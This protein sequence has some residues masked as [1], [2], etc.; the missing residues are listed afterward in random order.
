MRKSCR[1]AIGGQVFI[2]ARGDVLLDAA[3]MNGVD[4]PHDCRAG[5]CG[6]CRVRVVD[7]LAIGGECG[8]P[9]A[10]RACQCRILSDVRLEIEAVPEVATTTGRVTKIQ[11]RGPDVVEVCIEPAQPFVYLPGQYVR[12]QFRGYPA[13]C[14][15]P[16]VSMDNFNAREFLHLQ[17]QRIRGGRVSAAIGRG[18]RVGHRVR[19]EGPLGTAFLRPASRRR[20]VLVSSGTGFA[21]IWSIAVAAIRE[22]R[23]RRIT[24]VVGARTIES[25]YMI[26]ALCRLARHPNVT[27][28]PVVEARQKLSPVVRT[29]NIIDHMPQLSADDTVHACGSP[30]LVRAVA[31]IAAE[32]GVPCYSDPFIPQDG[33]TLFRALDWINLDWI[34]SVTRTPPIAEKA[35]RPRSPPRLAAVSPFPEHAM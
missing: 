35:G 30:R 15:S 20:L 29:G 33:G 3:L 10:V 8:E 16:T 17:V 14:Y 31:A 2:A 12:A 32:A 24:L 19:I 9:G 25:L 23:H 18:I 13:R 21:P 11:E 34:N 5:H 27:I 1:V 28:I 26:N 6:T 22:Y 7:G 4:I